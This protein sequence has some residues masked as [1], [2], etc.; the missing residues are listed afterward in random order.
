MRGAAHVR[1]QLPNQ[2]AIRWSGGA[3]GALVLAGSDGHGSARCF[4]SDVGARLAV[5]T[6][7]RVLCQALATGED[8]ADLGTIERLVRSVVDEWALAVTADLRLFPVARIEVERLEAKSGAAAT[9]SV[10]RQPLLA[11]GATLLLVA[12]TAR[13]ILY[14]QLGDGDVV[15]VSD[16][17][18]PWRPLPPDERLF[19]EQT[20]SLCTPHAAHD[21]RVSFQRTRG[22]GAPPALVLVSTDGYAN[23]FRD[24]R[25]FLQVGPDL[26]AMVRDSGLDAVGACLPEWL[27]E[28]S[29]LGSGDDVTLGILWSGSTGASGATVS[30]TDRAT[31]AGGVW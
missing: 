12:V 31:G 23:S 17:G 1:G 18:R 5:Q 6:G 2:D 9:A 30:S 28:A 3:G 11:Y 22:G 19:G 27:G 24:E 29:R 7:T 14:L 4:R 21:F 26:L 8:L 25:G 15:C 13:G 16:A 20:T 10:A